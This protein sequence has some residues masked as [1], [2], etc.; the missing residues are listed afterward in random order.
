MALSLKASTIAEILDLSPVEK[1]Q[2][3]EWIRKEASE[4]FKKDGCDTST[5][6]EANAALQAFRDLDKQTRRLLIE[7]IIREEVLRIV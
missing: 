2:A 5:V 4:Q 1:I 6:A 3:A 7:F